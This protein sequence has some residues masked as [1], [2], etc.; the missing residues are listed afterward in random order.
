MTLPAALA[1]RAQPAARPAH[2]VG[3]PARPVHQGGTWRDWPV[4]AAAD[5]ENG[6]PRPGPLLCDCGGSVVVVREDEDLALCGLG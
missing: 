1:P 3:R 5:L 6:M 4:V 2:A